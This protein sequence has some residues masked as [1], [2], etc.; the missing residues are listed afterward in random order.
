MTDDD[1]PPE[2]P[3]DEPIDDLQ[4]LENFS[5]AEWEKLAAVSVADLNLAIKRIE[6]TDKTVD[7]KAEDAREKAKQTHQFRDT[8]FSTVRLT[9]IG[10]LISSAL[11]MGAYI[12]SQWG[13]VSASAIISFNAAVVVNVLGLALIL[14]NY[15]F[16]KG[17]GDRHGD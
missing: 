6:P 17:G 15:L 4:W 3:A 5:E 9:L 1:Q 13:H 10:A 2:H 14:A 11:I 12:W 7:S 16:P 8:F